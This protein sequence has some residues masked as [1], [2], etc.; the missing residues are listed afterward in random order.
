[1][2]INPISSNIVNLISPAPAAM[3]SDDLGLNNSDFADIFNATMNNAS[4]SDDVDKISS[5]ELLAGASDDLSGMMVDSQKAEIALSLAL[6]IR[7]KVIDAYTQV[8]QM[9]V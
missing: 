9:Q 7:N 8:M 6:S 1:M 3:P 2:T 5:V 4:V